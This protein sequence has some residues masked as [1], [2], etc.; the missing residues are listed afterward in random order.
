MLDTEDTPDINILNEN[1]RDVLF[2]WDTQFKEGTLGT[3]DFKEHWKK[4]VPSCFV[5]DSGLDFIGEDK[6]D[7]ALVEILEIFIA[8]GDFA[9][10]LQKVQE[11]EKPPSICGRVFKVRV[12]ELKSD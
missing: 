4:F 5:T 12:L 10:L 11:G 9:S 1:P 7:S 2:E 6:N 8:G 3:E